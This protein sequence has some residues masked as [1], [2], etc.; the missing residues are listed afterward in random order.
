MIPLF[1]MLGVLLY[2]VLFFFVGR[3]LYRAFQK[4]SSPPK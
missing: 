4:R 1:W 2:V 3:A